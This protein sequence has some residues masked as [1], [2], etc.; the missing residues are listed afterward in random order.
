MA[1]LP[2]ADQSWL[3]DA[4]SIDQES[5]DLGGSSYKWIQWV[6]GDKKLKTVGGPLYTGGWFC[7][8]DNMPTDEAEGWERGTL[9]HDNGE[10]TEGWF[11]QSITVCPIR[12][13]R[14][15]RAQDKGGALKF[16][17]WDKYDD[18]AALGHPSGK[19]QV[20][21]IVKGLSD[22]PMVLTLS[23]TAGKAFAPGGRGDSVM[24]AFRRCVIDPTNALVRKAKSKAKF[25]W[26]AFW[27]TAGATDE[28]NF[29]QVGQGDQ[30]SIVT[31]PQALGLINKPTPAQLKAF[32]IGR[33][34][35]AEMNGH[36]VETETWANAWAE[37]D[38]TEP[39]KP[40]AE[41][42]IEEA[43]ATEELPF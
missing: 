20:L 12:M 29:T 5:L 25:T 39:T 6:H 15:W 41:E 18:A 32:Y 8:G 35:L 40:A 42:K 22:A 1:Q 2:N 34:L 28:P 17:S 21:C 7:P 14:C 9:T 23:G 33:D 27:L 43:E 36:Y 31:P 11:A 24:N 3:E 38:G 30:T 37:M 16:F 4:N 10:E 26:R 19:L 13:R